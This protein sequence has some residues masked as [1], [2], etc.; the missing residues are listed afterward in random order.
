MIIL[1]GILTGLYACGEL[2][3]EINLLEDVLVIME[4]MDNHT[5]YSKET[6]LECFRYLK[7]KT[8]GPGKIWTEA[9]YDELLSCNG[10]NFAQ[11]WQSKLKILENNG[12]KK[13]ELNVISEFGSNLTNNDRKMLIR[14]HEI[15]IE[16]LRH[17]HDN[18]QCEYEKK[19]GMYRSL[20]IMAGLLITVILI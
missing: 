7:N 1:S 6:Y 4:M 11:V 14:M 20:G 12:L 18:L 9:I 8:Q 15:Y 10:K 13:Q 19:A 16:R 5:M 3:K 2:K 17:I